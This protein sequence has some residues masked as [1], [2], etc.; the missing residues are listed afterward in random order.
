MWKTRRFKNGILENT[1]NKEDN[2]F[3]ALFSNEFVWKV[4]PQQDAQTAYIK[5]IR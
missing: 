1:K 3:K 2:S 4:R 5:K